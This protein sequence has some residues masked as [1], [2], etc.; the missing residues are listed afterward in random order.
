VEKYALSFFGEARRPD[1]TISIKLVELQC[2]QL[3]DKLEREMRYLRQL[4]HIRPRQELTTNADTVHMALKNIKLIPGVHFKDVEKVADINFKHLGIHRGPVSLLASDDNVRDWGLFSNQREIELMLPRRKKRKIVPGSANESSHIVKKV[5]TK[6]V[7]QNSIRIDDQMNVH[8]PWCLLPKSRQPSLPKPRNGLR[9]KTNLEQKSRPF[10]KAPSRKRPSKHHSL[11]WNKREE[12]WIAKNNGSSAPFIEVKMH[13][14]RQFR[15]KGRRTEMIQQKLLESKSGTLRHRRV[16]SLDVLNP[17]SLNLVTAE[18]E[19]FVEK[20]KKQVL[21]LYP[22]TQNP[23]ALTFKSLVQKLKA[24]NVAPN[25]APQTINSI[26]PKTVLSQHIQQQEALL[27]RNQ[28]F[29]LRQ[30]QAAQVQ[31]YAMH[32]GAA[33]QMRLNHYLQANPAFAQQMQSRMGTGNYQRMMMMNHDQRFAAQQRYFQQ[34]LV[35]QKRQAR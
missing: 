24:R 32:Q 19:K 6:Q 11:P 25:M 4:N 10:Q 5:G 16:D 31:N 26:T 1:P 20:H 35:A 34:Q 8:I 2:R 12:S 28:Q 33:H 18:R 21:D 17:E 27:Q 30:R 7:M 3:E 29:S 9:A 23:R 22:E 14:H 15:F 13:S